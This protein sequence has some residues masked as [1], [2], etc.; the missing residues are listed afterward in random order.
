MRILLF[1]VVVD[2]ESMVSSMRRD[3]APTGVFRQVGIEMAKEIGDVV[4]IG[5][6]AGKRRILL[7]LIPRNGAFR[8]FFNCAN[9]D[10]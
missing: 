2:L 7:P 1:L 6:Q 3:Q 4:G 10:G 9:I 8:I 5:R